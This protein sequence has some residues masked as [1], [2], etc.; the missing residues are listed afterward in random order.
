[1]LTS[2]DLGEVYR[3]SIGLA[4]EAGQLLLDGANQR[5]QGQNVANDHIEK[6]NSVDIVTKTDEGK[7]MTFEC[8]LCI[9]K[10]SSGS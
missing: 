8:I 6:E 4:K 2:E 10:R 5:I 7:S 3:F 1:M 9:P